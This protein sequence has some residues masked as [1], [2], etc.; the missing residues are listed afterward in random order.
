MMK[1]GGRLGYRDLRACRNDL[2]FGL[3]RWLI[4]IGGSWGPYEKDGMDVDEYDDDSDSE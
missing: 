3:L 4:G 2:D 1:G